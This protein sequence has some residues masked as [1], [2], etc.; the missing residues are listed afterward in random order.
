VTVYNAD[1]QYG[2]IISGIP[3]HPIEDLKLSDIRILY[4]G[5]GTLAQAQLEPPEAET[6][7]PEPDMFGEIPA[8]GF[9]VRHVKGLEM[10][11][12]EVRYLSDDKRPA[13]VLDDVR[14]SIFRFVDAFHGRDVPTF[15]L[16]D[17][18]DFSTHQSSI[19]DTR[20][21]VSKGKKTL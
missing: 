18:E 9:F 16:K 6:A 15:F 12:V 5:G 4:K 10:N 20:L 19:P 21:E 8:Y 3:G 11:N 7:Y 17:V 13:F 1:A 14:N 2:S